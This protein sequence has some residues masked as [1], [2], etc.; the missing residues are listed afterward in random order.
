MSRERAGAKHP[1][2]HVGPGA[3]RH[4]SVTLAR[5]VARPSPR[6]IGR[7]AAPECKRGYSSGALR[8]T[9]G[10]GSGG[11]LPSLPRRLLHH[12]GLS[13]GGRWHGASDPLAI[14]EGYALWERKHLT[15]CL[16]PESHVFLA[17]SNRASPSVAKAVAYHPSPNPLLYAATSATRSFR[18]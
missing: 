11:G 17:F 9:G 7:R 4:R 6:R 14:G 18:S 3:H 5:P 10:A 16:P 15:E 8:Q 2:Q 12:R 1:R 13:A